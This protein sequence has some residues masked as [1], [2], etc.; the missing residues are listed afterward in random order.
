MTA[1]LPYLCNVDSSFY[2]L[3]VLHFAMAVFTVSELKKPSEHKTK[4]PVGSDKTS[5]ERA[6]KHQREEPPKSAKTTGSSDGKRPRNE[7]ELNSIHPLTPSG[8]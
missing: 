8:C 1:E 6:R 7:E 3:F 5:N 4:E 2:Q